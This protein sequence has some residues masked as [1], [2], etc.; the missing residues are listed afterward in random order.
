MSNPISNKTI[1]FIV[2]L[3]ICL[4]FMDARQEKWEWQQKTVRAIRLTEKIN[5]DG[6]LDEEIWKR[7][8]ETGFTQ[9]E[10]ED[11]KPATEK[12]EVWLAYDDNAI[13]VA[14][15]MTDSEPDKIIS[16]LSRRD[17][18]VDADYFLFYV[19]PY[20]DKRSGFKFAVNPSG[21]IADWTM[22]NDSWDD[23]S[24]DGVWEARTRIDEKGWTV[25]M[26]IP[27]DQLRF[28]KREEGEYTW[29]VNFRR[30]IKRKNEIDTYSW[31]PKTESGFVS[32]FA[33][34][35]N[36]KDIK[37]K[38]LL[39]F[40]P[41]LIGKADFSTA[42]EG[43]PFETG[44][45]YSANTGLDIKYGLKNNLTLDITLNPDFGQV[46]VD[47]AVI[48]LSAAETYYSEKR[49]FFI[50]GSN[51]F[52][53]GIGGAT[54]RIGADWGDPS[55]FY[56]RRI[57]R[58]PQGSV[59]TEGYV[60]Y[61][62]RTTILMAAKLTGSIGRGWNLGF[63]DAITQ[64]E[65]AEVD[66]D[67]ER[68]NAEVE[69][70]SNYTVLRLNREFNE[71]RQGIGIIATSVLRAN[72]DENL[73]AIL[74]DRAFS[75]G[76]DGW[77]FLDKKKVWVA[78]GW[79]GAT[80]VSGTQEQILGLQNS[81]PHYFQRPDADYIEIDESTTSL[82][83]WA[84]RFTV[85]K[86][87]G[88]FLFNAALGI[89]SPGFDSRD[90][91]FQYDADIIN[92]HI[93]VGYQSF[94]KWW[95][96]RE[97]NLLLFTQRNYNFG[98]DLVGEQ[99]L[100]LIANA[101]LLNYWE[102]YI[103]WSHNPERWD[104]ER[105]RGGPLMLLQLY[106]WYDW[107]VSS[108]RRKP[109]VFGFGGYHLV[110][111]WGRTTH[112]GNITLEWKPASNFYISV[113]PSYERLKNS[114]QWVTNIDDPV[115][116]E[117]FGVRHIFADLDQETMACSLRLNW[118]FTPKLSLQAYIQPFISVGS[119][120][121]LKE[122]A[123]PRTYDFNS[124]GTGSSTISYIDGEYTIDPGDGG[125]AFTISDPNFN[126]KSLR[127]T[128]VLRWEYK[129]GSTLYLVWTQNRADFENP[130]DLSFGRDLGDLLR[131]PGDNIF[132]L[133]FTYRFKL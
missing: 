60:D 53:F 109:L 79:L 23:S 56:S 93:M 85:N 63:L 37:P 2:L 74:D 31:C 97:W 129:P 39:E 76:I 130:G 62:D 111:D 77:T 94:K 78:T 9:N 43:N 126:Y 131:A 4:G 103:Q 105:T 100:I 82:S 95:L 115:M 51:I 18:F 116:T 26:K 1:F 33:K 47:P 120:R 61:P 114:S 44:K 34:M 67:G 83:G 42:E 52:R 112:S 7:A 16:L 25:E 75:L 68:S 119:Y 48:N 102:T 128:V 5:L 91:G 84:G 55:F 12:T 35:N 36:M 65:F 27:F 32:R 41:Y 110:T 45:D 54:S 122:F 71:G 124:Y 17:D 29:G 13:Y 15:R 80:Q 123:R 106:N 10:P 70:F 3:S 72:Q 59:D 38:K 58:P 88:N 30:Y 127:G 40:F 6:K 22:Y 46:E 121:N 21:S 57:G 113:T 132:M 86:E 11:G 118:I 99:R 69:P 90:M 50:E 117:T 87:K 8:G 28:K 19:D 101:K 98:W 81:W 14:A 108:D 20:Y 89:I 133:K 64:R 125:T 24:W 107:Y 92:G 73:S 49:P 96:I 66:I 104:Q